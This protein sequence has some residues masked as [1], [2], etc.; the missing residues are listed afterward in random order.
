MNQTLHKPAN[1]SL[2]LQERDFIRAEKTD[3]GTTVVC[4][5]GI[6]WLTQSNDLKDYMLKTG[7]R[8]T[9]N[10]K[11]TILIEAMSEARV[12]IVHSN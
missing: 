1:T 4:E 8:M 2:K 7:E 5:K 3:A 11:S 12:S 9:V 6:L 10:Q